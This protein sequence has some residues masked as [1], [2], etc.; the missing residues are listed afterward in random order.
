MQVTKNPAGTEQTLYFR[1]DHL[2]SIDAILDSGIVDV[3]AYD[4]FGERRADTWA[5]QIPSAALAEVLANEDTRTK[6]GFTDHEHL[7]EVDIIHM[8]GRIYDPRLGRF[9]NAD[10]I[11]QAPAYSQSYNRYAYTF[12]SPLSFVDPSGLQCRGTGGLDAHYVETCGE[13]MPG[14]TERRSGHSDA[15]RERGMRPQGGGSFVGPVRDVPPMSWG[16][17]VDIDVPEVGF[18]AEIVGI[19]AGIVEGMNMRRLA[20]GTHEWFAGRSVSGAPTWKSV[21]LSTFIQ[22]QYTRHKSTVVWLGRTAE[23]FG[24][25]AFVIG[26]LTSVHMIGSGFV[27]R[28][29]LQAAEGI[30]DLGVATVALRAGSLPGAAIAVVYL[31]LKQ[32]PEVMRIE[33]EI[34]EE[35]GQYPGAWGPF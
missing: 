3:L 24:N 7:D 20:E 16:V 34:Y 22:N 6:R 30:S 28:D 32:V 33:Q 17:S 35:T 19:L 31:S 26:A 29:A 8:N 2:G 27:H 10:P 5:S 23:K 4:P 18:R 11:V 1:R 14:D 9:L 15:G 12:N 25:A 13:I 21:E